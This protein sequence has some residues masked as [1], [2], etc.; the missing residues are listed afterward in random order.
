MIDKIALIVVKPHVISDEE[1]YKDIFSNYSELPVIVTNI[2]PAVL[3]NVS[4]IFISNYFS[5]TIPVAKAQGSYTIEYTEYSQNALDITNGG[6]CMPQYV[7]FFINKDIKRL[8]DTIDIC[9]K[10][11]KNIKNLSSADQ[12]LM[13]KLF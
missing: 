13:S 2:H 3:A 9:L 11:K 5:Y 10:R 12:Y 4:K 7:D 8:E 1:I 6:S